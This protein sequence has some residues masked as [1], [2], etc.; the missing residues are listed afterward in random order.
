MEVGDLDA[1]RNVPDQ[2]LQ[3]QMSADP[4]VAA[5][6]N[7]TDIGKYMVHLVDGVAP[8]CLVKCGGSGFQLEDIGD[9]LMDTIKDAGR[10]G[11]ST[12]GLL[13]KAKK[14]G[15]KEYKMKISFLLKKELTNAIYE[16]IFVIDVSAQNIKTV[17]CAILGDQLSHMYLSFLCRKILKT[18][19]NPAGR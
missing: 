7:L 4:A 14:K 12:H 18:L 11:E 8:G 15:E 17:K 9:S 5:K 1:I 10:A 3:D 2:Q 13:E 16:R 19:T 6:A